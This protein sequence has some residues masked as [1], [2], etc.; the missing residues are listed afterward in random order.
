MSTVGHRI[1]TL[2]NC[3]Q[4]LEYLRRI[5]GGRPRGEVSHIREHDSR[6]CKQIGD[7]LL[8]QVVGTGWVF[9]ITVMK[10]T[11]K[12]VIV[13]HVRLLL[14]GCFLF[15]HHLVSNRCRE[16]IGNNS[17]GLNHLAH[18][19]ALSALNVEVVRQKQECREDKDSHR[20][21]CV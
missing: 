4:E 8:E 11:L 5:T 21:Q 12:A 3:L 16:H 13:G 14:G 2:V 7:W 1:E 19:Q 17:S 15:I 18:H 9:N 6:M 20:S 10:E